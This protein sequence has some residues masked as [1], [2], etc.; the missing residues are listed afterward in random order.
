MVRG[1]GEN[2]RVI[3]STAFNYVVVEVEADLGNDTYNNILQKIKVGSPYACLFLAVLLL[4]ISHCLHRDAAGLD[5]LKLVQ[6]LTVS[7]RR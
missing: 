2:W 7:K 5:P 3:L 6:E 4:N 1:W